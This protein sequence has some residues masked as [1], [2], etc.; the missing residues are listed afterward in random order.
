MTSRSIISQTHA[1]YSVFSWARRPARGRRPG[2]VDRPLVDCVLLGNPAGR[3]D[4]PAQTEAGGRRSWRDV[5]V[6][7]Q[8]ARAAGRRLRRVRTGVVDTAPG[9]IGA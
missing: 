2:G 8:G 5:R 4:L 9:L 6:R 1:A 3:S 7:R